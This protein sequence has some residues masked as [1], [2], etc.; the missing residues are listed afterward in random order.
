LKPLTIIEASKF[1]GYTKA[2]LYRL[3]S[4]KK[5]PYHK[6]NNGRLFFKQEELES[7]LYHGGKDTNSTVAER[8][9]AILNTRDTQR[10]I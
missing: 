8:A 6:P 10:N 1:T 7:Y 2:Y 4:M 9:D 5:I 3:V